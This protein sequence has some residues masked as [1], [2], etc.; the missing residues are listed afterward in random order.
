M[1]K[2]LCTAALASVALLTGCSGITTQTLS[3]QP[4]V[5]IQ[6]QL[7]NTPV[8]ITVEDLRPSQVVGDRVDL[9]GN[10]APILLNNSKEA[11][12][13]AVHKALS[14]TGITAFGPGGHRLT[15]MLDKLS[16]IAKVDAVKQIVKLEMKLRVK[17]ER[18]GRSYTGQYNTQRSDE[19]LNIP[20]EAENQTM[21]DKL[22]E[23]NLNRAMNDPRLLEFFQF[24]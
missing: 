13:N 12:G 2:L 3:L 14:Q 21:I 11:L 8:A 17:V 1:R 10:R 24:N 19:F 18:G 20:T 4:Q 23:E 9:V 5:S 15:V 22:V 7:P 6:R 16:Y